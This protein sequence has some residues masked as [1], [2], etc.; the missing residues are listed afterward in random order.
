[1]NILVL[2]GPNLNLLGTR[3]PDV[4]GSTTLE[5][6]N[7]MLN[8]KFPTHEFEFFQSNV[9]GELINRIQSSMKDGTEAIVANFGGYTHTSIALRDALEP[10]TFP[11]VEVHIS[12]IHAREEFREK[13]ITGKVMN[14]IITGFGEQSYILGVHAVEQLI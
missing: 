7:N 13:S 5:D 14:G 9:E 1:M 6:I 3:N 11:K 12:N 10:I 2:N 8:T 4:Y